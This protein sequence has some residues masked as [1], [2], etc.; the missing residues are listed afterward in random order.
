MKP[1]GC[2]RSDQTSEPQA[3]GGFLH[4]AVLKPPRPQPGVGLRPNLKVAAVLPIRSELLSAESQ[5]VADHR[6]CYP[7]RLDHPGVSVES[8]SPQ[9][10]GCRP[11]GTLTSR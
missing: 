3:E 10:L 7:L 11:T 9:G 4:Y 2:L 5:L 6:R 1:Q 8:Q